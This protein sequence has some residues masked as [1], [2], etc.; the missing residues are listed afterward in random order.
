MT[1]L[2]LGRSRGTGNLAAAAA[3]IPAGAVQFQVAPPSTM[4][5]M[6]GMSRNA[7]TDDPGGPNRRRHG[8]GRGPERRSSRSHAR[9]SSDL[10]GRLA[11][12]DA[13]DAGGAT[14]Q[15]HEGQIR[16]GQVHAEGSQKPLHRPVGH[17]GPVK[18]TEREGVR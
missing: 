3:L 1:M 2:D 9:S 8:Q 6:P 5:D 4:S 17:P 13:G 12:D 18:R 11:G 16:E 7:G 10:G 15:S 14:G